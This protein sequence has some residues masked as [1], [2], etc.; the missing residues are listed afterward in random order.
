MSDV[1]EFFQVFVR[2][3]LLNSNFYFTSG[4]ARLWRLRICSPQIILCFLSLAL[5]QKFE[6]EIH[7]SIQ[8]LLK[9]LCDCLIS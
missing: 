8:F 9:S 2:T 4:A 6:K 5:Q 3:I 1:R 7:F